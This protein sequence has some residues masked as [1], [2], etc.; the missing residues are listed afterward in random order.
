MQAMRVNVAGVD[1]HQEVLAITVLL[2]GG[3]D[4]TPKQIQFTSNT[5]TED[6]IKAGQ[7]LLELGVKEVAMESTGVYWKPLWH[8]WKPMAIK[9]TVG[10]AAN[11]KNVPGRK[12]DM[13]DSQWIAELHR[14][15]LIKP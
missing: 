9:I 5:F 7:K 3:V 8:V 13:N 6:L 10:Q 11:I 2:G 15:G 14:Y 1:V 4:E 12:T